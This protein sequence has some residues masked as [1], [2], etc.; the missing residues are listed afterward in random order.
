MLGFQ[1]ILLNTINKLTYNNALKLPVLKGLL[2]K[3]TSNICTPFSNNP[4]FISLSIEH[5]ISTLY[6]LSKSISIWGT[7]K[8]LIV[9]LT[10]VMY[11]TFFNIW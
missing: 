3:G 11:N 9:L 6:P 7:K 1:V 5:A 10:V 2:I 8:A 4:L